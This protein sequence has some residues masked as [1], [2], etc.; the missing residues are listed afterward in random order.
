[1]LGRKLIVP[2]VLAVGIAGGT[3]TLITSSSGCGD[4][5]DPRPDGGIGDGGVDVPI[6]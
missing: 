4:G 1:M 5:D 2:L 3:S 6:V